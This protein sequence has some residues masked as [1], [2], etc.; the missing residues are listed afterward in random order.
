MNHC[1]TCR[2]YND[3]G[4]A[5]ALTFSCF[6][7]QPFLSKDRSRRWFIDA[8]DRDREKHSFHI[9]AYVIMPEDVHL[10]LWPTIPNYNVSDILNSTK[11]SVSKRAPLFVRHEAEAF[12]VRMEDRQPNGTIHHRFWQRG[13]GYDRNIV[14]PSSV[15]R[16]IEYIHNN[17]VRRELCSKPEDWLW[18]SAADYAG[19]RAGPLRVDRESVPMSLV[20]G[21]CST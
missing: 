1:K 16:Q 13:G 21:K 6:H 2:R 8:V 12:L 11:Q 7:R 4:H 18:S 3:Q 19:M 5:H 17:P 14:E 20:A 10:L 9:W 15:H